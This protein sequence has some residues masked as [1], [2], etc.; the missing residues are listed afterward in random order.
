[1]TYLLFNL[2]FAGVWVVVNTAYTLFD[3]VTGFLLGLG[4]LWLIRPFGK[5]GSYFRRLRAAI[6]LLVF[7][8]WELMVSV[9]RVAREVLTPGLKSTPDIVYVPLDAKTDIEMT[10]L[11][12]M[13][14][15][16]PGTLSLDI[17]PDKTHLIVHAMFARD[18][19]AVIAGIKNG[20]EK[21]LL[22]VTRE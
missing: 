19:D 10:L 3:F 13:V 9:C 21:K 16:T 5:N 20:L 18:P 14:S 4:C 7:F 2:I 8:H 17:T 6:V 22:E 12:N 11:A 1:M 15:L